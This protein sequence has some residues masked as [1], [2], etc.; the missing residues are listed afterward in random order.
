[1]KRKNSQSLIGSILYLAFAF[2]LCAGIIFYT[3]NGGAQ[4]RKTFADI[5]DTMPVAEP[6]EV[7]I[8][9]EEVPLAGKPKV[10]VTRTKK[11][12]KKKKKLKKAAKKTKTTT[13]KKTTKKKTSS[14]NAT[15]Y[16]VE[17]TT[18]QS[19]IQTSTKKKSKVQTIKL[20]VTTT[21]KTT[22]TALA[23]Q[24]SRNTENSIV[25][26]S[27][28]VLTKF[29]DI[30]GKIPQVVYDAFES[31]GFSFR[32]NSALSTTGVFSV[33]NHKIEIKSGKPSYLIHELGHF[34]SALKFG[35]DSTSEWKNIYHEEKSDYTGTN[36]SYVT[37]NESEYFAESFRDYSEN[38][39][40]L[41]AQRPETYRYMDEVVNSISGSDVT[42]FRNA[43]SWYW[44]N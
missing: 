32:V 12:T 37:K 20:T 38:P 10:S 16:T 23:A 4:E 28:P 33:G 19:V 30:K 36:K 22:R 24:M 7:I 6:G 43:Y 35:A 40:Q 42:Q 11:V 18:V 34:V 13:K 25:S 1:M 17:E 39:Q 14:K 44:A 8:G 27:E 41:K 26:G 2:V 29:S 31:L 9:E 5:E 15:F 3:K 21:V